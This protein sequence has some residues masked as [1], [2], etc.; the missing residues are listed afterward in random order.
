MLK[1]GIKPKEFMDSM[2]STAPQLDEL[3]LA[4]AKR[5]IEKLI[6]SKEDIVEELEENIRENNKNIDK[7]TK[8]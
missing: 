6:Q 4:N 8:K 7:L 3:K 1:D 5:K 2:A